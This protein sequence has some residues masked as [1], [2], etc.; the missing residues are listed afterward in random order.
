MFQQL[1]PT[2]LHVSENYCNATQT[3]FVSLCAGDLTAREINL[4]ISEREFYVNNTLRFNEWQVFVSLVFNS[5]LI[6]Y[7]D[8]V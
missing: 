4:W 6:I 1:S 3:H 8:D 5:Y 2:T 7:D